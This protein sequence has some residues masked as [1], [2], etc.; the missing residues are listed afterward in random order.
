MT[1]RTAASA[2]RSVPRVRTAPRRIEVWRYPI[3]EYQQRQPSL[4]HRA[5][6]KIDARRRRSPDEGTFTTVNT[7]EIWLLDK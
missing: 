5:A 3:R 2:A 4:K 7:G 6:G 1:L